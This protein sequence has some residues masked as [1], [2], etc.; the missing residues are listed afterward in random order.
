MQE[1][2]TEKNNENGLISNHKVA[3]SGGKLIFENPT[4][5]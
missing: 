1:E 3:D 2:T 4:L 5:C